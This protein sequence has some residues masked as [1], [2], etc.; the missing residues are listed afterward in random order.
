MQHQSKS[1]VRRPSKYWVGRKQIASSTVKRN[2][3]FIDAKNIYSQ[4]L[5]QCFWQ[6]RRNVL[7]FS[8]VAVIINVKR[9]KTK[10]ES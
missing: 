10:L 4:E 2:Y 1:A 7:R 3:N 6:S 8:C 5:E 9:K